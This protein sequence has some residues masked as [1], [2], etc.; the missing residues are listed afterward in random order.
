MKIA[1]LILA[2]R[3]PAQLERLIKA[4]QHPSFHFYIHIDKKS[5]AS[6]FQYLFDYKTV[7]PV[8]QRT[9]VYWAA[10]GTIQATINGFREMLPKGYDYINVISAQDF[11]LR[12]A[13]D[14]YRYIRDRNGKE[15]ITCH[16]I[17]V[18][19]KEAASRVRNYHLINWQI[20]G[21]HRLE[22]WMNRV[23]PPR[24]FPIPEHKIVGR[25]NWFTLSKEAVHYSLDFID[26]HPELVRYYKYCWGADEFIFSTILYNSYF[27]E[28]IVDNL[29][30]VDWSGPKTGH[31]RILGAEDFGKLK[32]SD[33]LFARKFDMDKDSAIFSLLEDWIK[34][35][36]LT[37]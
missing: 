32:A 20:P 19:W 8:H 30:Y 5:D 31:P 29:V 22:N 27:K 28:R 16:S 17:D 1:H 6:P 2:H 9:K 10:Y 12:S 33:K 37:T 4:L 3:H 23:L 25:A 18:E 24:K 7:F 26:R 35:N 21:R 14:I 15:F 13:D 36:Q 34:M 11:P